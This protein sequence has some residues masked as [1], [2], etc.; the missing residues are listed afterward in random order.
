MPILAG[1]PLKLSVIEEFSMVTPQF[2]FWVIIGSL[3]LIA[4]GIR[5]LIYIISDAD[6]TEENFLS[7]EY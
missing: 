5:V 6:E 7:Q 2:S 3:G 4:G 1:F